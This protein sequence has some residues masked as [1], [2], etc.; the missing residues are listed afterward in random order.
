MRPFPI[1]P[2]FS[3]PRT[4]GFCL[5][6]DTIDGVVTSRGVIPIKQRTR[7]RRQIAPC[8]YI[9][10]I[11]LG[12]SIGWRP[13]FS[14]A[15]QIQNG[16]A[17]IT[18]ISGFSARVVVMVKTTHKRFIVDKWKA[19]RTLEIDTTEQCSHGPWLHKPRGL[20]AGRRVI[21]LSAL[22]ETKAIRRWLGHPG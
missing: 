8:F 20:V 2:H 4:I 10:L 1:L 18:T 14:V 9:C 15:S 19:S 21:V 22:L 7:L 17:S 3:R 6:P 13:G 16:P 12:P 5:C 11:S